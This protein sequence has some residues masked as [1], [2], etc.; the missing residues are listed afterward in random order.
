MDKD[1]IYIG[2]MVVFSICYIALA[3][4]YWDIWMDRRRRKKG[5][6]PKRWSDKYGRK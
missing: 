2:A 6:N 3:F 4:I 1:I 5:L